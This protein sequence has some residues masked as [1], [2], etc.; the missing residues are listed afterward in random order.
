MPMITGRH[1]PSGERVNSTWAMEGQNR[2]LSA[3]THFNEVLMEVNFVLSLEPN[4]FTTAIM[5]SAIWLLRRFVGEK[6]AE[7]SHGSVMDRRFPKLLSPKGGAVR[8]SKGP[9]AIERSRKWPVS[10]HLPAVIYE[11]PDTTPRIGSK[12][13]AT[14]G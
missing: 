4:P 3:A 7:G 2:P 11:E 13:A 8:K 14:Y 9:F 10:R 6:I 12:Y 1:L 5:T